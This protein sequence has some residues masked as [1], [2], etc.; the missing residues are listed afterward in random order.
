LGV[1]QRLHH[2]R[3]IA[4]TSLTEPPLFVL[5]HWR[6]GT[7]LLHDLL[8]LDPRHI[9]PTTYE[10]FMPHH[11]L[12][13]ED[14]FTRR[15]PIKTKRQMDEVEWSWETP[16]EDEWALLLLGQPSPYTTTAWPNLPPLDTDYLD[17]E[18]VSGRQREA[19][20]RTLYQFLQALTVRR[21]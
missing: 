9:Y 6:S 2:G 12:L 21:S 16:Q 5:G 3:R 20:K 13:S 1:L 17:L 8:S 15:F 19:W 4:R 11:F 18:H 14:W 10:C 7:T